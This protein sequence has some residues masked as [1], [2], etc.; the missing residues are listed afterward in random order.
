MPTSST[1][2]LIGSWSPAI[3]N[4]TT[5]TY[6]FT[7]NAG[8]CAT[9]TSLTIVV[10]QIVQP[11]GENNQ[12]FNSNSTLANIAVSPATVLW[13]ASSQDALANLNQLPPST[14]L[15]NGLTYY[16]VNVNGQCRSQPFAV[17]VSLNLSVDANDLSSFKYYPNPVSSVL[18]ITANNTIKNVEVYN[19]LGQLLINKRFNET[20]IF[21]DLNELPESIYIIKVKSESLTREF[22]IIKQ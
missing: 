15:Q 2:G 19:L 11:T 12:A 16:A 5:T 14:I 17:T 18:T 4:I 7:P 3:N 22:K 9:T 10:D 8:Q 6:T 21:L 20:S 13:Y 1:N